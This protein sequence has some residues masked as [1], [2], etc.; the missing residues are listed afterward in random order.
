MKTFALFVLV[1][2][3]STPSAAQGEDVREFVRPIYIHGVPYEKALR[4]NPE[5]AIPILLR[6]LADPAE[7]Q[8]WPNV[9]V[10][11]GMVGDERAVEPLI[12]FLKRDVDGTL[13]HSHYI[14]KSSVVMSLGYVI[15][16]TGSQRALDFLADGAAPESW[17]R[18]PMRWTSPYHRTDAERNRQLAT[19]SILGLGLSGHPTAAEI[20]RQIPD[21]DGV[22]KTALEAHRQ[23]AEIGLDRYY[24]DSLDREERRPEN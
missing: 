24:R 15:N 22:V 17:S 3:A 10:T 23:I 1:L 14:A 20:L 2:A 12:E 8:H 13:S 18:Q 19:M 9:V 7:E 6:M 16:K 5:T 4:F 21:V 11:L